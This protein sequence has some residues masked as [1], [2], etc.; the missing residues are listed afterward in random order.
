MM[1]QS[2]QRAVRLLERLDT[3]GTGGSSLTELAAD[4]GLKAPTTHNFLATLVA[5]GYAAQSPASRR[6]ALGE[7][8]KALG[9]GRGLVARLCQVAEAPAKALHEWANET[10][11]LAVDLGGRRHSV[12]SYESGHDLRVGASTGADDHFYDT[13]TGRLLLAMRDGAGVDTVVKAQGLPGA[14]WPEAASRKQLDRALATLRTAGVAEF[15]KPASHISAVAVPVRLDDCPLRV[16]LGLFYP[17]LRDTPGR[18]QKLLKR[19]QATA[20]AIQKAF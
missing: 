5:L 15:A 3:A 6:Y 4:V 19:M 17:L 10:V 16:A 8:A 7:R 12:L 2:V 11:I 13:A 9:T 20:T 1:I 18:R 14:A